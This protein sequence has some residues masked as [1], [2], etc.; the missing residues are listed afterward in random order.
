VLQGRGV[1]EVYALVEAGL[2]WMKDQGIRTD[3]M[4]RLRD[5]RDVLA[6]AHDDRM[7]A[8]G[9]ELP[10]YVVAESHSEGQD[11]AD[12][13]S[14]AEA[15]AELGVSPR[16]VRRLSMVYQLGR[17]FGTTWAL[18]RGAVRAL[19]RQREWSR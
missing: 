8:T 10:V 11:D 7:S 3:Q 12:W 16:Q 18:D 1:S 13:I 4:A 9:R 15:S 14:V 19:K 17:R 6:Q 2:R 5:Y